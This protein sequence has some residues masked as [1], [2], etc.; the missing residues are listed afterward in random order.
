M[1]GLTTR[2]RPWT[3]NRKRDKRIK[4]RIER[5]AAKGFV[6]KPS[7]KAWLEAY[8]KMEAVGE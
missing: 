8:Y 5:M 2:S 4:K 1:S 3:G 7:E 6:L